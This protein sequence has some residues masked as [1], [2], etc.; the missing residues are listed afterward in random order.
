ML[1]P[2]L[3]AK[4]EKTDEACSEKRQGGRYADLG[5]RVRRVGNRVVGVEDLECHINVDGEI[6]IW[7]VNQSGENHSSGSAFASND[8]NPTLAA[9]R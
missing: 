2:D 9:A 6:A 1:L 7:D 5:E 3:L 4:A 8:L